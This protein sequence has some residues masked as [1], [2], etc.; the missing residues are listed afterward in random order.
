[1]EQEAF[2]VRLDVEGPPAFGSLL[3]EKVQHG[4]RTVGPDH[5][6]VAL[7]HRLRSYKNI[8]Y[9]ITFCFAEF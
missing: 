9:S 3:L 7:L 8:K 1:M 2:V 4:D 6:E 5:V